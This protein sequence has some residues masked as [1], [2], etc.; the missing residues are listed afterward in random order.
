MP[1]AVRGRDPRRQR[2]QAMRAVRVALIVAAGC[3]IVAVAHNRRV[4]AA[5]QSPQPASPQPRAVLDKYCVTCHNTRLKTAGLALD[6][7]D[8]TQTSERAEVLEKI[9]RKIRTGAM[10]P[11]GRP[12]PD[13]PLAER[14][15]SSLE[16]DLDRAAVEHV[17]QLVAERGF[18]RRLAEGCVERPGHE[19]RG[20]LVP[21]GD[22]ADD[23][24][25]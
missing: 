24:V 16:A 20:G 14:V 13:K 11:V 25:A 23:L 8:L 9:V 12:R 19:G 5:S 10:P 18:D 3:A 15:A 21:G 1:G 4:A 6:A 17:G 22:Q 2:D 7:L